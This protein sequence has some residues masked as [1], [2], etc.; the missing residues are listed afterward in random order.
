MTNDERLKLER[1]ARTICRFDRHAG[2]W[3]RLKDDT[4]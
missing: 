2:D 3:D 4:A 1:V